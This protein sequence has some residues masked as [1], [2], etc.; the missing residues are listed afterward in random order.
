M[1]YISPDLCTHSVSYFAFTPLA[2]HDPTRVKL[3]VY[4]TSPRQDAQ[5]RALRQAVARVS[6][7]GLHSTPIQLNLSRV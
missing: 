6:G 5:T 3:V 1:G 4:S 2:N 7:R